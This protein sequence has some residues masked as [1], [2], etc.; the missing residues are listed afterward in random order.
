MTSDSQRF[1]SR[2]KLLISGEYLVLS[3]ALALA[4]PA[5]WGQE[6]LVQE[7]EE[8]NV[9]HWRTY[10]QGELWF[11]G[12][13]NTK[14]HVWRNQSNF[15]TA[16]Y[17]KQLLLAVDILNPDLFDDTPGF[18]INCNVEFPF[19][20]G[21]GSSATLIL[22]LS[23]WADIDP[24]AINEKVSKGSGYDIATANA[25]TP[26]LYRLTQLGRAVETVNFYPY[27]S[28]HLYFVYLGEKQDTEKSLVSFINNDRSTSVQIEQISNI[29]QEIAEGRSL[30]NC[31]DNLRLHERILSS[32]LGVETVQ[33]R[34]FPD[35]D[36]VVKSLG[37][38]GGDFV[39]AVSK[40]PKE[41]II[42]YFME[43][44]Y[45]TILSYDEMVL[46]G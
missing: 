7:T 38:W 2:G 46:K 21:L 5:V 12:T 45:G 40:L 35:F 8:P 37:A 32:V 43:N 19:D 36:G 15:A 33:K 4:V 20:W 27:F 9:I 11:H 44:G 23:K 39:L 14:D 13:Y 3:G 34:L 6:M 18:E 1:Y 17:L 30:I 42:T 16:S 26:I 24:Y 10:Q 28:D 22:N 25:Q 31:M 41:K 29:S